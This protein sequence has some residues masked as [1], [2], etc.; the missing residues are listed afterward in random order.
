MYKLCTV[1]DSLN[2]SSVRL[3]SGQ[4]RQNEYATMPHF[5]LLQADRKYHPSTNLI[6]LHASIQILQKTLSPASSFT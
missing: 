5:H 3:E 6:F 4:I 1:V 2:P